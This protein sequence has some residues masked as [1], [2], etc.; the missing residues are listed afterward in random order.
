MSRSLVEALARHVDERP[1]RIFTR[2]LLKD[3]V[4]ELSFEAFWSR[5][6]AFARFLQ[7]RGVKSDDVVLIFLPTSPD[8]LPAY[9]GAMMIGAVPS[10]MPLPSA[11]QHPTVY[12]PSHESLLELIRPAALLTEASH[13]AAMTE[14]GLAN[15]GAAILAV[16]DVREAGDVVRFDMANIGPDHIALLQHSSGT[17]SLKK[18]VALSHGAILAQ[19]ERYAAQ[20]GATQDDAIVSWLPLYHDM[21]LIACSIVPLVVGQTVTILDPFHWVARPAS[22]LEALKTYE[23][24]FAWL[25][26]FAYEHMAR[27]VPSD[28]SADLSHVKAIVNCSEPCKA[29]TFDRFEERFASLGLGAGQLQVCYAMAETVF[30]VSQTEVGRPVKRLLA[31]REALHRDR[32]ARPVKDGGILL[33]STGKPLDGVEV[34]VMQDGTA[35][36]EGHVGEIVVEAPFLFDGYYRRPELTQERLESGR[37]ST[38]DLG[39]LHEGELYVLGRAD[40][41]M[42][43]NGRNLHA[44]EV[45]QIVTDVP[46]VK[47]GRAVAFGVFNAA[48]ASEELVI[49]AEGETEREAEIARQI[50]E[51]VYD[52]TNIE[53]KDIR[54]VDAGWVVKTTSGKISREKN[55]EKYLASL[56]EQAVGAGSSA[57]D[58][59]VLE[60][61]A[62]IIESSFRYPRDKVTEAT[63]A[64]DVRGWDSLA[65]ASFVMRVEEALGVKFDDDE[66][67]RFPTVG[68]LARRAQHLRDTHGFVSSANRTILDNEDYRVMRLQENATGDF[69]ILVF[70]GNNR[71]KFEAGVIEFGAALT[72][73]KA[74]NC[75]K[76]FITDKNF[77]FYMT[78]LKEVVAAIEPFLKKPLILIGNSAGG[79]GA[80]RAAR[81]FSNIAMV[82][83][84]VP[85]HPVMRNAEKRHGLS[86]NQVVARPAPDVRYAILFGEVMD[87]RD[88][89]LVERFFTDP[90]LHFVRQVKNIDHRLAK[91]MSEKGVLAPV[92]DALLEP[93]DFFETCDALISQ[94]SASVEDLESVVDALDTKMS[95]R[96]DRKGLYR[97]RQLL[98]ELR[99]GPAQPDKAGREAVLAR[100]QARKE[101]R[102]NEKQR[103]RR[104]K[105]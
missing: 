45:E 80:L 36:G 41:L 82:Y 98:D 46:G 61:I 8:A 103:E 104:A 15:H 11:K 12:W 47:A 50:G 74:S 37:Y 24:A 96:K 40:D 25:P 52:R 42:I 87:Y 85:R 67:Y 72:A 32:T 23:G 6:T 64:S 69:D 38:R 57:D 18:G 20:L 79:Y 71:K 60:Q 97:A 73:G 101:Q 68:D 48:T 21:G 22:M 1:D 56:D 17:T 43:I 84:S 86:P 83:S 62:A 14:H 94:I 91:Y 13:R 70:A 35:V 58:A 10:F 102:Q 53:V 93:D 95:G 77:N 3:G 33:L 75:Q 16:E 26:N 66:I 90:K 34:S 78:D 27:T 7:E 39:F 81:H 99:N 92:L 55:R 5:S 19:A 31:D 29:E 54:V 100:R 88:K 51:A 44:H 76:F 89:K 59:T 65:H 49:V 4:K 63:V 105:R 2:H 30:A 28:F 9:I